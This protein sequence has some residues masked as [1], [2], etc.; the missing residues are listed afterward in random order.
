MRKNIIVLGSTG[1]IGVTTLSIIKKNKSKF[2]IKLLSTKQNAKKVLKQALLFKVNNVIIEDKNKY[3]KFKSLFK[4]KKINLHHGI[5]SI[6]NVLRNNKF[7]Y[8]INAISGIFGLEPTL[9]IIPFTK[10]I[11]IA[12]K[13]SIICG[14]SLIEKKLKKHNTNFIPI[15]SEHFS[16][17][18]LIKNEKPETIKKIVLTAS[19]GPFLHK[20][21][22]KI[23]NINPKLALKHPNWRMGKKISIDSSTM[24]NKIFEFIE[25]KK[26]FNL[27]NKDISIMIHPLS[28]VHAIV[29][30]K[31]RLIKMLAHE[32]NMSIPISNSLNLATDYNNSEINMLYDKLNNLVFE[33]PNKNDFP[34]LSILNLIPDRESYFEIILTTLND[35]LVLKYLEGKINYISIIKNIIHFI[36]SP[37]FRKFYKL[38]PKN[39]YDINKVTNITKSYLFSNIKYYEK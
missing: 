32:T 25:A 36:K 6:D 34:L 15:D 14:W 10:N 28:F 18:K 13:E 19:G 24:M 16:I 8:C 29:F 30:F 17:W 3:N 23:A 21:I 4:R 1:S 9:K 2:N 33:K 26:I 5:K 37:Y 31:G 20:S 22:K 39:L 35:E 11:L 7:E 38:K 27:K 12:N